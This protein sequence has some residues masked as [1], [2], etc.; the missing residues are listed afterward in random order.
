MTLVGTGQHAP[1]VNTSFHLLNG[2]DYLFDAD[3]GL[4][5]YRP[6]RSRLEMCAPGRAW[7]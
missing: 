5:G 3:R 4:V 1:F 2:F 6:P 7:Q